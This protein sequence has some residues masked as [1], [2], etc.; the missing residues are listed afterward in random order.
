VAARHLG[1]LLEE[2]PHLGEAVGAG[3]DRAQLG[4][5]AGQL[6]TAVDREGVEEVVLVGEVQVEGAVRRAG[7]PHDVVDARRV[8]APLGEHAGAGVEQPLSRPPPLRPQL[9]AGFR[10]A[11]GL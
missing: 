1:E 8:V 3:G 7:G 4:G 5:E 11:P 10:H 6:G 9:A 2:A